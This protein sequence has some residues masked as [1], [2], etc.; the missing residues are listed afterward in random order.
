MKKRP[1]FEVCCELQKDYN[2]QKTVPVYQ[3]YV[4]RRYFDNFPWPDGFV[5]E[6][7]F[8]TLEEAEAAI[9]I[10]AT[11]DIRYNKKGERL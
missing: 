10:I 5:F 8:N 1:E 2:T 6:D 3:L 9:K 4:R 11:P 7:N